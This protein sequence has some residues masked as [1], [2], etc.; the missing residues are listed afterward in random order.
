MIQIITLSVA[1]LSWIIYC[2]VI[3]AL[4]G[5]LPSVSRSVYELPASEKFRF[6]FV[7]WLFTAAL[8]VAGAQLLYYI[9]AG[10]MFFTGVFIRINIKW[11]RI[12]HTA[13]ISGAILLCFSAQVYYL[14]DWLSITCMALYSLF[15]IVI[16]KDRIWWIEQ[17]AFVCLIVPLLFQYL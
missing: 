3:V 12:V 7:M 9:A 17:G 2:I 5:V 10:G 16:G 14:K 1:G 15:V 4:Y 11:I 6:R 13:C 8:I